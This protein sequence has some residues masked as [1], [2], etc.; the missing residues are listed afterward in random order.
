MRTIPVIDQPPA[1][2]FLD[3]SG[4]SFHAVPAEFEPDGFLPL[5]KSIPF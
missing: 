5:D 4:F 2:M 1:Q 3:V